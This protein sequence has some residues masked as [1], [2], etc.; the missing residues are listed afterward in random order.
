M[1]FMRLYNP[2]FSLLLLF[3]FTLKPNFIHYGNELSLTLLRDGTSSFIQASR[4]QTIEEY[5]NALLD[6]INLQEWNRTNVA[7]LFKYINSDLNQRIKE[8]NNLKNKKLD[9]KMLTMG[10]GLIGIG[11]G[12]T[13]GT[14]YVHTTYY[15]ENRNQYEKIK[16]YLESNHVM[17][18]DIGGN[19][20][21]TV[22][23]RTSYYKEGEQLLKLNKELD[24]IVI[25][26]IAGLGSLAQAYFYGFKMVIAAF[27]P[28]KNDKYL[29][30]YKDMLAIIIELQK[31]STIKT[32][33]DQENQRSNRIVL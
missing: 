27:Y 7:E 12:L 32:T 11:I 22:P 28:H 18:I 26:E 5:K 29:D 2:L 31:Q 1:L 33:K 21:L 6:V 19:I 9:P 25:F 3:S 17:V 16:K 30:K 20:H 4:D 14:H 8:I 15:Q 24:P 23:P 13:Y 10:L